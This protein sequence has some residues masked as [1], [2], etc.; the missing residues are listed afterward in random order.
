MLWGNTAT[1]NGKL[2]SAQEMA[3]RDLHMLSMCST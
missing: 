1:L 2:C 3:L